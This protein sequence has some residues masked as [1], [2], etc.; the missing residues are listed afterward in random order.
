M[1][2][3][4]IYSEGDAPVQHFHNFARE[5]V[6][7]VLD[8][9]CGKDS[10]FVEIPCADEKGQKVVHVFSRHVTQIVVRP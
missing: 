5:Q 9:L 3:M 7:T 6:D 1:P 8:A 2:T 10:V 4:T